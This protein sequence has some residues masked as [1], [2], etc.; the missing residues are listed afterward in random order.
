MSRSYAS[1]DVPQTRVGSFRAA[2]SN[3]NVY[4][5]DVN[6][7][8]K[9]ESSIGGLVHRERIVRDLS[10]TTLPLEHLQGLQFIHHN[11]E[12]LD[13]PTGEYNHAGGISISTRHPEGLTKDEAASN[14]RV[15]LVHEIGHHVDAMT[16]GS[17][18]PDIGHAE[19]TAV[20][21]AQKHSGD[22]HGIEDAYDS[23]AKAMNPRAFSPE[24]KIDDSSVRSMQAYKSLRRR[25]TLPQDP[26]D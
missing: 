6:G 10:A 20:N 19:A 7:S 13:G 26:R 23:H 3:T 16:H 21:Y 11:A 12:G 17:I 8:H 4:K 1:N 24:G 14:R 2:L 15:A 18:H 25:G 9:P 22:S 5:T